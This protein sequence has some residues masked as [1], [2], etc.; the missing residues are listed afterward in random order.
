MTLGDGPAAPTTTKPAKKA[1]PKDVERAL[2]GARRS[3]DSLLGFGNREEGIVS[4]AVRAEFRAAA[5]PDGTRARIV[6]DIDATGAITAANVV[7]STQGDAAM[8]ATMAANVRT[9]LHGSVELG[10]AAKKAGV[11]VAVD[12]TI[13]HVFSNGTDGKPVVGE[14]PTMPNILN[15]LHP[16]PFGMPG[17]AAWGEH[18]NGTCNL[19]DAQGTKKHIEVKTTTT[20]ILPDAGPPPSAALEATKPKP[21]RVTLGGL[22]FGDHAKK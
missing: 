8:W 15:D 19:Q 20:A 18:P 11:R 2:D 17:G 10:P 3:D 12:A 21:Q 6:V 22:L 5:V 7:S 16:T 1:S 13:V 14:C 9:A 4:A